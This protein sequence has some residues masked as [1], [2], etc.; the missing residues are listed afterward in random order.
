MSAYV[1]AYF[2]VFDEAGEQSAEDPT[3]VSVAVKTAT[4]TAVETITLLKD[5]TLSDS[6]CSVY[7]GQRD[8]TLYSRGTVYTEDLAF[9]FLEGPSQTL[10]RWFQWPVLADSNMLVASISLSPTIRARVELQ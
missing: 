1:Y 8:E 4:G 5:T 7:K 3:D 10:R 2:S 6:T 9:Q